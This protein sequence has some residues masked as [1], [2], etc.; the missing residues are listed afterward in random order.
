MRLFPGLFGTITTLDNTC[1]SQSSQR[2]LGSW[3]V[4]FWEKIDGAAMTGNGDNVWIIYDNDGVWT[5]T[6]AKTPLLTV[7]THFVKNVCLC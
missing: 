7:P 3:P 5:T 1:G 6:A 4:V 2:R